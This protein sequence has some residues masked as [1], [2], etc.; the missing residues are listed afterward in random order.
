MDFDKKFRRLIHIELDE[1]LDSAEKIYAGPGEITDLPVL[2]EKTARK[3]AFDELVH[4]YSVAKYGQNRV[5]ER[6]ES[7]IEIHTNVAEKIEQIG[8]DANIKRNAERTIELIR[9]LMTKVEK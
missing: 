6:L 1:L 9:E 5:I 4:A 3:W 7:S 2:A 8:G